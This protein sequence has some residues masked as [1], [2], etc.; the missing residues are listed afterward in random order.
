MGAWPP[1]AAASALLAL[2]ADH[3]VRKPDAFR[4]AF[5]QEWYIRRGSERATTED[6]LFPD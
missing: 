5:G 3:V 1:R 6:M 4:A 2:A